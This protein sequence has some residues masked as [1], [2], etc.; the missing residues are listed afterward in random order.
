MNKFIL[1][2]MRENSLHRGKKQFLANYLY[3]LKIINTI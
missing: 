2:K 1:D 3:I